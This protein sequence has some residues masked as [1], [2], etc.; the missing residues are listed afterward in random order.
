MKD[1]IMTIKIVS[2]NPSESKKYDQYLIPKIFKMIL[3]IFKNEKLR[4][5]LKIS[6]QATEFKS[7]FPEAVKA[8]KFK[9]KLHSR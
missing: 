5:I 1:K 4:S 6:E 3:L 9:T 7:T 8:F 2:L